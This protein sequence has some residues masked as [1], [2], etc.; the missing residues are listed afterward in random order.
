MTDPSNGRVLLSDGTTNAAKTN[1]NFYLDGSNN[2]W[3]P[4]SII[5]NQSLLYSLG[6]TTQRWND[7]F[8]G[9]GTINIAGPQGSSV[10]G[11]IGTNASGIVY[12]PSG[13][14]SP[15]VTVGPAQLTD[16]TTAVGGWILSPSGTAGDP[17]YDLIV[18]QGSTFA[19]NVAIPPSYSLIKNPTYQPL[20]AF[21][22]TLLVSSFTGVTPTAVLSLTISPTLSNSYINIMANL[23]VTSANTSANHT[24]NM[25]VDISGASDLSSCGVVSFS[26][27]TKADNNQ[28]SHSLIQMYRYPVIQ[29]TTYTITMRAY[30]ALDQPFTINHAHLMVF[31]N[32]R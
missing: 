20:S 21:S 13:F 7:M 24:A 14:A 30:S 11:T 12:T 18:T 17:S 32:M 23:D 4:G 29:N 8:V 2:V 31:A 22:G 9:P 19:Y 25:T 1:A 26:T 10:V 3:L 27:G 5:P 28:L 16:P 15:T 6:S